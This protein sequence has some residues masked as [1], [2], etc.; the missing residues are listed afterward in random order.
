MK[1]KKKKLILKN[2]IGLYSTN[3]DNTYRIIKISKR[4]I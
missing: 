2:V 4:D 1:V 3:K